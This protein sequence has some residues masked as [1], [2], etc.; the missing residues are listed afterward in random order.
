[1][2]NACL[3]TS[4]IAGA[5]LFLMLPAL[6][7]AAALDIPGASSEPQRGIRENPPQKFALIN[8]YVI[9]SPEQRID[10]AVLLIDS[11]HVVGVGR[12]VPIPSDARV[13]DL[14][15]KYIF[16]GFV[17]PYTDYGLSDAAEQR[18]PRPRD[19][20]Y[21]ADR[22]GGGSSNDAIHAHH[23]WSE[24]FK[25][26]SK[27]SE[28]LMKQGFTTVHS[29][30]FDGI[31]RGNGFVTLLGDG[32]PNMLLLE[33]VTMPFASF[34]KGTSHQQYPSSLMGSIALIRQTLLDADWYRDARAAWKVNPKQPQPEFNAT[35]D[36]LNQHRD[37]PIVF[38]TSDKF[39]LLRAARIADEFG[40]TF[41]HAGSGDEYE[42]VDLIRDVGA[43]LIVPVDF[44]D[45]PDVSTAEVALDATLAELRDWE[46]APF[47]P[48]AL[49]DH[50][51]EFAFT[52]HRLPK[53]DDFLSN[54]RKAIR[55]GLSEAAA[56]AALTTVPAKLCGVDNVTG[57]LEMGMLANFF[58]ADTNVLAADA[59]IQSVWVAGQETVLSEPAPVD[60][61]GTY[62][63]RL[64][65]FSAEL[66]ITTG[67]KLTGTI[68]VDDNSEKLKSFAADRKH[69]SFQFPLTVFGLDGIAR[70]TGRVVADDSLQGTL[71]MADGAEF[72]WLAVRTARATAA[73]DTDTTDVDN[74]R[75]K[76]LPLEP[77][78]RLTYPNRA[79]GVEAL[80]QQ[81][82]LFI[83]NATVWTSDTAGIIENCD[84][85]VDKG[86]F[87]GVG[88][89]LTAPK[90]ALVI[91]GTG[92]HV[93]AGIIDAH[94]HIAISRGVN[95]GTDA[96]TPEVRIGDVV[97]ADDRSIYFQL[98][99]GTTVA[100]LLHGSA[101][102]I[103]GEA[104]VIKLKW[105]A[106]PEE[107]K[108]DTAPRSIKW[109][110]GE[111]VK[112]SNWG[113]RM[114]ERYPQTRMGVETIMRDEF[115]AAREYT[116][117]WEQ[118]NRLGKYVKQRTVPPRRDLRL[119]TIQDVLDMEVLVHC[120]SYHQTEILMLMRLAEDFD[121]RL[122]TFTHILEGYKVA[123]EMAAHGAMA[124]AFSDWWAYKF[125]VYDAIPYNIAIMHKHG[126]VCGVN[127]DNSEL[128][129]R[130]NHE[131]AKSMQYGGLSAEEAL[132]LCT[133]N[134]AIQLGIQDR[135]GSVAIGKDADFVIWNGPPLSNY[136]R[137]EQTWIEGARY[138]DYETDRAMQREVE[139]E[140]QAL[141][142]KVLAHGGQNNGSGSGYSRGGNEDWE[143][144]CEHVFDVW[145]ID[146]DGG[147][148]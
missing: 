17:D 71:V 94:S 9:V 41:I 127:S 4:R 7:F 12:K 143:W 67:K 134:P 36:A 112:Q 126:I 138:F 39:S 63:A 35:L 83:D 141:I 88:V 5:L 129:R 132:K 122:H 2:T 91:D 62:D 74:D 44:P 21:T 57:T 37:R 20:K 56:L 8:A 25:P 69:I 89:D 60:L 45:A 78:S 52:T 70:A 110:L 76:Q 146:T 101:N 16:P 33:P 90:D 65:E 19:P 72:D 6:C 27:T 47:N 133:I 99:G 49:A 140:R 30:R 48:L 42:R 29:A 14:A 1:M 95:E 31:F 10:S 58:I 40:R 108:F 84:I 85:I 131:A 116:E 113:E 24:R 87:S 51:I 144:D 137:C 97:D 123:P 68:T 111:N 120:H 34:D 115:R 105:G 82:T 136:T 119:E 18:G 32:L 92:K 148:D 118:W 98:A 135:V 121:F 46:Q 79:F 55:C 3:S 11:G 139:E 54:V 109:A 59:T 80:P 107:L 130:L 64:G 142:Q 86:R 23:D 77:V 147:Q 104:Q 73:E 96:L 106:P 43:S 50:G 28:Q 145:H 22:T 100:H 13:I 102:P 103:G 117:R 124:S 61:A 53:S 66:V 38:E 15:G 114:D 75:S 81:Q 125:E 93:T 128:A 26:D